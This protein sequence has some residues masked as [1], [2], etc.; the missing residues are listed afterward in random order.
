[1]Q[2]SDQGS[3][4]FKSSRKTYTNFQALK[5]TTLLTYM[6]NDIIP[7]NNFLVNNKVYLTQ[8]VIHLIVS[9]TKEHDKH[10][11]DPV[12]KKETGKF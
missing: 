8:S 2:I 12:F 3:F 10:I 6:K 11:S 7:K 9:L 4:E 5:M 1:M